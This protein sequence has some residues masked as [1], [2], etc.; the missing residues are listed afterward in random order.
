LMPA[1]DSGFRIG[2]NVVHAKFGT[3]VIVNAEGRGADARVQV[4]FR[5]EGLKWLA[6]EFARLEAA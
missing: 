5:N 2:Q 6:L 4:N 1:P 3:G